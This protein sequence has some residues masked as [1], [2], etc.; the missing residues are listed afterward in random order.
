[1]HMIEFF[2][3]LT[4]VFVGRTINEAAYLSMQISNA[5][6]KLF[7]YNKRKKDKAKDVDRY[8]YLNLF[9]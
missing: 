5:A 1:M 8:D 7:I 9:D 3:F 4:Q 6:R 2:T